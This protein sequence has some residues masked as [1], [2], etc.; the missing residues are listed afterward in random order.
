M[1]GE[2]GIGRTSNGAGRR[3]SSPRGTDRQARNNRARILETSLRLFN[4]GGAP[5]VSTNAIAAELGISPGNL[6]YHF[7]NKE[8]II[9]ELWSQVEAAG[10]RVLDLPDDAPTAEVLANFFIA[11]IDGLW[12]FRFFFR[13]ADELVARDPE[14]ARS[15]QAE[16]ELGRRGILAMLET[17]IDHGE[18]SAPAD[19]RDLE[20]LAAN[21]QLVFSNWIRFATTVYGTTI[22][23]AADLQEGGLHAF[24]LLDSYLDRNY[25]SQV[26]ALLEQRISEKAVTA[27]KSRLARRSRGGS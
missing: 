21:L 2:S 14:F 12:T 1:N 3:P 5:A 17:L 6:Y 24:V 20:R 25:A 18:M 7:A 27:T 9:R 10:D 15:F 26:R 16:M 13:D 22:R 8:Q 11:S 23:S 4:E 19:R